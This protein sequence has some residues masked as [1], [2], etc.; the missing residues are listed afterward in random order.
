MIASSSLGYSENGVFPST[1]SYANIAIYHAS[2]L[3]S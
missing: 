3:S 1:N 2:H